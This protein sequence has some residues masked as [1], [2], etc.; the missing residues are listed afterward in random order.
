MRGST[1][2]T[3]VNNNYTLSLAAST[4]T[5]NAQSNYTLNF[6][7][8][9]PL[10]SSGYIVLTLDPFLTSTSQQVAA[11]NSNLSVSLSGSNIASSPSVAISTITNGSQTLYRLTLSNLNTSSG[12]IPSQALTI[13]LRRLL[14]FPAVVTLT[15]FTAS[16]FFSNANFLVARAIYTGSFTLT[17]GSIAL[18][19]VSSSATTT[20]TFTTITVSF[21]NSNPI[22]VNGFVHLTLPSEIALLSVAKASLV[23]VGGSVD[24]SFTLW[25]NNNTLQIIS[26]SNIPSSSQLMLVVSDIMTQNTTKTT[27]TFTVRTFDAIRRAI[28]VSSNSL[29]LIISTGNAFNSLSMTRSNLTNSQPASYTINF[30]Q[31]QQYYDVTRLLIRL[32]QQ[33]LLS[34]LG[35][36]Y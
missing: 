36:I 33:L 6:T 26:S 29:G 30:E 21:T 13:T 1:T 10:S 4:S 31:T 14:N 19:T 9:D 22:P 20:Y 5:V 8:L 3:A 28:D 16:T 24:N 11:L 34:N 27:S 17:V 32:D 15:S 7:M 12:N 2:I 35:R 18:N 23:V 25:T